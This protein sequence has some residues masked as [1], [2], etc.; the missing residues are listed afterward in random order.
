[1]AVPVEAGSSFRA[2]NPARLFTGP[3]FAA[4]NGRTYDVSPDGQRF[5]MVKDRTG[6]P[7]APRRIVVVEGFF[8][9]LKRRAAAN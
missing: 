9:E 6:A 7:F 5:L 8:E 3:Y 1:M 4:L 2:G